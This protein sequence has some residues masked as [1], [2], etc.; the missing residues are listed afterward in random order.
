MRPSNK[1]AFGWN[2][3][4][5]PCCDSCRTTIAT[6]AQCECSIK[7]RVAFDNVA[8]VDGA[9][10][11]RRLM[12]ERIVN[13]RRSLYTSIIVNIQTSESS[14]YRQLVGRVAPHSRRQHNRKSR[15]KTVPR[16]FS[17]DIDRDFETATLAVQLHSTTKLHVYCENLL[18]LLKQKMFCNTVSLL[19]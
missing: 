5:C 13:L 12:S 15:A 2:V 7:P 4:F 14:N 16:P 10:L 17:T 1:M 19:G 18:A 3:K 6:R 8:S 9:L 11:F